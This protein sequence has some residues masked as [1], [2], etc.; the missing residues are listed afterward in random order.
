MTES[1]LLLFSVLAIDEFANFV[2]RGAGHK[3]SV[4]IQRLVNA[5]VSARAVIINNNSMTQV[6][7]FHIGTVSFLDD[8]GSTTPALNPTTTPLSVQ[9]GGG[10]ISTSVSTP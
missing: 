9:T 1:S 7:V 4:R 6:R 5:M 3:Q 10:S 8:K 2:R